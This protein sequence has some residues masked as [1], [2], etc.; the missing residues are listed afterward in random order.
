MANL[1]HQCRIN[2]GKCVVINNSKILLSFC[3]DKKVE[4]VT[5]VWPGIS[6]DIRY[7]ANRPG[8]ST[9]R[10]ERGEKRETKTQTNIYRENRFHTGNTGLVV[11]VK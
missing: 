9:G 4:N 10:R 7:W 8:R 11:S 3:E 6:C 5:L 2:G 1:D